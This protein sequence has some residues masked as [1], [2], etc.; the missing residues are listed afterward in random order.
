MV[1]FHH[2][3]FKD[4]LWNMLVVHTTSPC[5][6]VNMQGF[7]T[8]SHLSLGHFQFVVYSTAKIQPYTDYITLET[9]TFSSCYTK[10]RWI[11]Q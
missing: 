1:C 2:L 8:W 5:I 10:W 9:C 3:Y 6:F 4:Y 11:E 7:F